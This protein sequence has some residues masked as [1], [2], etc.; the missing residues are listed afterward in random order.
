MATTPF[1]LVREEP[2]SIINID[3]SATTED[4]AIF[5]SVDGDLLVLPRIEICEVAW[6]QC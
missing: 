6:P 5:G 3:N 4:L 2:R 1:C